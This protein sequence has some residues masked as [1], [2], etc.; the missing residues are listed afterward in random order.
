[1]LLD[2]VLEWIKSLD[3][4]FDNYYIGV[5]DSKKQKSLGV[6]NLKRATLPIIALGGLKNTSYNVKRISLLIHWNKASDESE[7][8]ATELFE[9]LMKAKLKKIGI[10]DV[11]FIGMLTNGPVDVGRDDNG[12]CEYV[13]EFEIY[14]KKRGG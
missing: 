13:I 12:I 7:S 4:Q 14:Y 2:D 5:L 6:Y 10:Y 3:I 9:I 8:K 1:M 11:N